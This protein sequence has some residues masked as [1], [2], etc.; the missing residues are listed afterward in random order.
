MSGDFD[1]LLRRL[2][3]ALRCG[4]DA[5]RKRHDTI[6]RLAARLST[7]DANNVIEIVAPLVD[8]GIDLFGGRFLR[9]GFDN[10]LG[11]QLVELECKV[12]I[13]RV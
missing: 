13:D 5:L 2:P 8:S 1:D 4:A 6:E 7:D 3:R 12:S 11:L 9:D 10:G